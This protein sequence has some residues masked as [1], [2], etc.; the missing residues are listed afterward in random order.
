MTLRE[1]VSLTLLFLAAAIMGMVAL[2]NKADS[3][4]VLKASFYGDELAG[5][6]TA[7]GAPFD[8][9]ALTAAHRTLPLGSRLLVKHEG[10]EVPVTITDRGP[11]LWTGKD[12][13]LSAGAAR[14]I[15]LDG[16]GSVQVERVDSSTPTTEAPEPPRELPRTGGPDPAIR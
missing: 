2:A 14:A 7:S 3:A 9:E 6:P 16:A 11:A 8:P 12:L 15:G 5:Y 13:D 10:L 1:K 4:E